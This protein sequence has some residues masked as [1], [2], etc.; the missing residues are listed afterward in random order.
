MYLVL[1]R[2]FSAL[3]LDLGEQVHGALHGGQDVEGRRQ[4]GPG[5]EIAHP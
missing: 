2:G 3:P 1:V 5:L 4:G